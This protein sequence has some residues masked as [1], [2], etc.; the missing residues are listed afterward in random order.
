M[1]LFAA[2]CEANLTIYLKTQRIY[3]VWVMRRKI[4]LVTVMTGKNNVT[5]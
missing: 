2:M 4:S 3:S 1:P 5:T